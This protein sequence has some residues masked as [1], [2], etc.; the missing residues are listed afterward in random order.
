MKNRKPLVGVAGG[1]ASGKSLVAR[2]FGELGAG[3]ISS[4]TLN[5]EVLLRPDVRR[6]IQSWWGADLYDPSGRPD[7]RRIADIVFSD[8]EQRRRLERLTHPLIDERRQEL[9]QQLMADDRVPLIVLDVPLL[10]EVGQQE[11]CD[12]VV[13]VEVTEQER[14]R[15]AQRDRGWDESELR[16]REKLQNP[17]DTKRNQSDYIVENNSDINTLRS[18]V[19][20]I[21]QQLITS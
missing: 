18:R 8:P 17:L 20:D 12:H 16:R 6:L 7:R 21:Y 5:H 15:R 2:L 1:I 4:D 11:L 13:F 10:F 9:M 3:V 14:I 19:A